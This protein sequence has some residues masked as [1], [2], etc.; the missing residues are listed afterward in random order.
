M[1][2]ASRGEE[3]HL[4]RCGGRTEISFLR[5]F[6]APGMQA[7]VVVQKFRGHFLHG[8]D[9]IRMAVPDIRHQDPGGPVDELIAINVGHQHAGGVIPRHLRLIPGA[10]RFRARPACEQDLG[11][12][13]GQRPL[14]GCNFGGHLLPLKPPAWRYSAGAVRPESGRSPAKSAPGCGGINRDPH[15]GCGFATGRHRSAQHPSDASQR[16][17]GHDNGAD[18]HWRD[19]TALADYLGGRRRRAANGAGYVALGCGS[20]VVGGSLVECLLVGWPHH[21]G[22]RLSALAATNRSRAARG[23]TSSCCLR[24]A[25]A[26]AGPPAPREHFHPGTSLA[27]PPWRAAGSP[28]FSSRPPFAAVAEWIYGQ[29]M[30]KSRMASCP[31]LPQAGSE[32]GT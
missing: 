32:N 19:F 15:V 16:D 25:A 29:E 2:L 20:H 21:P 26:T 23:R 4:S 10:L 6:D 5:R 22:T 3:K 24:H 1:R 9:Q 8:L 13:A 30:S 14:Y 17:E 18:E 7:L 31:F 28:W 27:G 12:R 11:S